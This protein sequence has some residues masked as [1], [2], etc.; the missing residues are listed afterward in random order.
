MK[1]SP[2]VDTVFPLT[3]AVT[4]AFL[5]RHPE[6][7]I[8]VGISGTGGG[9]DKFCRGAIDL[10]NAS[11]PISDD[12]RTACAG[13]NVDFLEMPVAYDALT[14]VVHPSNTWAASMTIDELRRLWEPK[15]QGKIMRWSDVR[16]DWPAEPITLF[17]P[18]P[19]SGTFDYFTEAVVGTARASRPDYMAS[20]DDTVIVK[21]VASDPH[22]LG[23]LGYGYAHQQA[24]ILKIVAIDA[25]SGP[26]ARGPVLP[27][28]DTVRRGLYRPLSRTLFVYVSA[29][30][31]QRPEVARF[32]D[33]YI[34]QDEAIVTDVGGIPMSARAYELVRQ[35]VLRRA[36]GT[37]FAESGA[38]GKNLELV[39]SEA[40]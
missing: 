7:K 9:F 32:V 21:G 20:E 31:A 11:R 33:F 22:A 35:R 15:A 39:L 17:G 5:K 3:A 30:S 40:R 27:S 28:P 8:N 13:G 24:S 18:G 6:V 38:A 36:A 23:Y 37:I 10:Q 16:A 2:T 29:K 1:F 34:N 4:E 19:A 14:V 26:V 12:E 25:A